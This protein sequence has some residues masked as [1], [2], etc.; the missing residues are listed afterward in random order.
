MESARA[1]RL[2]R[3][4]DLAELPD[5]SL[6]PTQVSP[7][8][9]KIVGPG[10]STSLEPRV[11]QVLVVL[12]QAEGAVVTRET[13]ERRCW[14]GRVGD[15]SL[16]RAV[17][18][19]RRIARTECAE[20]FEVETIPRTGYRLT[21]LAGAARAVQADGAVPR[22]EVDKDSAAAPTPAL[23]RRRRLLITGAAMAAVAAV[24][25]AGWVL[26]RHQAP[27][28]RVLALVRQGQ[29]AWRL[30]MPDAILHATVGLRQA[31]A[32]APDD[33]AVRGWLALLLRHAAEY[34]APE[35]TAA[36]VSECT[37]AARLA[38]DLDPNEGNAHA[39]LAS[40]PPIYGDWF[41]MRGRVLHAL[42]VAPGNVAATLDLAIL[43]AATGRWQAAVP[44]LES[45][46]EREPL[47]ATV[48]FRR[49]YH[50]W[51]LGRTAEMDQV[52]D[53]ALQLWPHHR[54][55]WNARLTTLAYT[56]RAAAALRMVD[57]ADS[58]PTI[59]APVVE[60]QRTTMRALASGTRADIAAAVAA[61]RAASPRGPSQAV[62]AINHL[63]ALGAVDDAFD[64]VDGYLLQRGPLTVPL[65][66]NNAS[67][68]M[69]DLHRRLTQM[70]FTP[71]SAPIRADSRFPRLMEDIRLADYWRR[72]GLGPS[73]LGGRAPAPS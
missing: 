41:G 65:F 25:A 37:Q 62:I 5:F 50:L 17:A 35:E 47:A 31:V 53:R 19:I 14:G 39:A 3:P 66:H 48:L 64:A 73:H 12:A 44:A 33:P 49:V 58:R 2:T 26:Q 22:A 20:S 1:D 9:R 46:L 23:P 16:N 45:I 52:A 43:E 15:D 30:A 40:L 61:N 27:D 4:A 71:V 38:L 55:V 67:P 10:G 56:G 18:M 28:P 70:L 8:R 63:C 6:G 29:D 51:T 59:P 57:D 34:S 69:T 72:T 21:R 7:A 36:L 42:M 13:I 54:A 68:S 24:G 60:L 11:M 32:L